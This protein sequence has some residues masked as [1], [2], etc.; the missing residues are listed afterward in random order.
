MTD[1]RVGQSV[2]VAQLGVLG[3][4]V[5]VVATLALASQAL[6]GEPTG[7][8]AVFSQC[9]TKN[10]A[11][12]ACIYA[13]STSGEFKV[14]NTTVP[15]TNAITLQGGLAE[16]EAFVAA[17]NGESLSKTPEKVPGGLLDFVKCNEISNFFERI[18]CELVFE[19]GATGVNE[20]TELVATPVVN[21]ENLVFEEGTALSL[22]VRVHLENAFLGDGCYIGSASHPVTIN[23]TTGTTTPL[24]PNQPI[25]GAAGELEVLEEGELVVLENGALVENAF[26]APG[27]EGC[28][29]VLSGLIDPIV[30]SKLELPSAAG[31]NTAILK[32]KLE[33][34]SAEGVVK[35][36]K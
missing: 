21:K 28:G 19:N 33:L 31:H 24:P 34:A 22:P 25:K 29:G 1:S 12:K 15:L 5:A 6:A 3:V 30:D 4:C 8:F 27:A 14:G 23:F 20:T 13:H 2:R 18:A 17:A 9:P 26:S 35:S 11:V 32:G 10:K 36:E 16:E 7:N